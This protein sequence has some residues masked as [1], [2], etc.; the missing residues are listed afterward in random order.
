LSS[1]SEAGD[2]GVDRDASQSEETD[3]SAWSEE[4][5]ERLA[6]PSSPEAIYLEEAS[7]YRPISTGDIFWDVPVP[8]CTPEESAYGLTMV[9]AH[10]SV[11][12]EGGKLEDRARAA[13]VIRKDGLR[14]TQWTDKYVDYFPLPLLSRLAKANGFDIENLPWGAHLQLAGPI[15]TNDLD[16]RRRVVCLRPEGV[17]VLLQRLV[18][19]DTRVAVKIENLA[20]KIAPKL[21]E[22]ELLQ[23]WNEDLVM[24]KVEAGGHLEKELLAAA[25]EFDAV[26]EATSED[27]PT[28]IHDL[29]ASADRRGEGQRLLMRELKERRGPGPS[30]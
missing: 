25:N 10:P 5:G 4:L 8:G 24:P 20:F 17:H 7:V 11:M 12:R 27:R 23:T 9:V 13:P 16:I 3:A 22:I 28:S 30:S 15:S 18:F 6:A 19:A 2:E 29:L 14:K 21:D 26:C 1:E